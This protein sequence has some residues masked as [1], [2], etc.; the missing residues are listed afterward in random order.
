M[1]KD[2]EEIRGAL[3]SLNAYDDEARDALE[4]VED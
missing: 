1:K 2:I 3:I 4:S